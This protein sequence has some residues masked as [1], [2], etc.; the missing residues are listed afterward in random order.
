[1][2]GAQPDFRGAL[3]EVEAAC[4]GHRP[5]S[6]LPGARG[7]ESHSTCARRCSCRDQRR[8]AEP[9]TDGGAL[10][11]PRR[12]ARGPRRERD[13]LQR[14]ECAS[15]RG[16]RGSLL[17]ASIVAAV[18]LI[19][20]RIATVREGSASA[21]L[22]Q[23]PPGSRGPRSTTSGASAN[24]MENPRPATARSSR[25]ASCSRTP[26]RPRRDDES[27]RHPVP[28]SPWTTRFS[29][30][31]AAAACRQAGP[32]RRWTSSRAA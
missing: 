25:A 32:S 17:A 1:V 18:V 15:L 3:A 28:I 11:A 31:R 26:P 13:L 9:G 8:I 27:L 21:R 7:R 10:R 22:R 30:Q 16:P 5:H 24:S 6:R 12:C 20:A 23:A 2:S 14:E 29:P 19:G 4:R